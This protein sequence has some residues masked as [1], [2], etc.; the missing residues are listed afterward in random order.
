MGIK[1]TFP[2]VPIILFGAALI[3]ITLGHAFIAYNFSSLH[4]GLVIA[5]GLC[6]LIGLI[7]VSV[8]FSRT[9]RFALGRR[10]L[11]I[12]LMAIC[13]G[14]FWFAINYYAYQNDFRWD[15]TQ[16]KRHT[17]SP[18]TIEIIKE[19]KQDIH[20]TAILTG[21]P[22]KYLE[23]LFREYERHSNGNIHTEILDPLVKLGYAA[24]FGQVI[25]SSQKK[26][27]V[28]CGGEKQEFDF[29]NEPLVEEVVT[30]SLVRVTRKARQAYFLTGHGERNM[31]EE[32]EPGLNVFTKLLL[33]NNILVSEIV[34]GDQSRIPDD[35][36]V[37]VIPGPTDH[38]TE[39]ESAVLYEYL[40]KGGDALF[41]IEHTVITTPDKPLSD[42]ERNKNPSMNQILHP[43]GLD[44]AS[45]VVV[46]L[47]SHASG[48]VGS[49]ATRNYL[50]HRAI[51]SQLD[52]TFYVRP[53][54]IRM[55]R[56]R[57]PQVK[58]APLVLTASTQQSWGETDRTLNVK[59]DPGVDHPGPVPIAFIAYE[60]RSEQK[61][62]DTRLIA[63]TD[64]DFISNAFI[65]HY[66]NAEMGLN[67]IKWLTELDYQ[68]FIPSKG[69]EVHK[70]DLTSQQKRTVFMI[71][72]LTLFGIGLLGFTVGLKKLQF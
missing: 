53:R 26:L 30:N 64:V 61:A 12:L 39:K 56:E 3:F 32:K 29:T 51:V 63:V 46:D 31:H 43:W 65:S 16:H 22:P 57:R 18:K 24:Q 69:I 8:F 54:S 47:A 5:G 68:V 62:T 72:L 50:T 6:L 28:Q 45:D 21:L 36:D 11:L 71:L 37:L 35:C 15:L 1:K 49:P 52:Y 25:D 27:I 7:G 13:A 9:Y 55:R 42:E 48:D 44:V 38:F 67:M 14:G 41:M 40:D 58:L 59:Y 70:F 20:I 17:L 34:L 2:F 66:S 4:K 33:A 10:I 23:D 60:P 19:I